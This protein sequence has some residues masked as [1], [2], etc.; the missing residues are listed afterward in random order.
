MT[1]IINSPVASP[2][3]GSM[4]NHPTPPPIVVIGPLPAP[5]VIVNDLHNN[6]LPVVPNA[7]LAHYPLQMVRAPSFG[8]R[9]EYDQ[10]EAAIMA[11][12]AL[13]LNAFRQEAKAEAKLFAAVAALPIQERRT[14]ALQQLRRM[15]QEEAQDDARAEMAPA[16][17]RRVLNIHEEEALVD[18]DE[19]RLRPVREF[20]LHLRARI[21]EDE[22]PSIPFLG[23]SSMRLLARTRTRVF[24]LPPKMKPFDG[25]QGDSELIPLAGPHMGQEDDDTST[26]EN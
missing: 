5:P 6:G 3:V 2:L 21:W 12:A 7:P 11:A 8:G 13:N 20:G 18:D 4:A 17:P 9:P 1:D 23:R 22:P 25:E 24:R 26:D 15:L 10:N 19:E 14:M 16:R